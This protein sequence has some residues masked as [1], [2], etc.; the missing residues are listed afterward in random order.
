MTGPHAL[1]FLCRDRHRPRGAARTRRARRETSRTTGTANSVVLARTALGSIR[2][3]AMSGHARRPGRAAAP[4][5]TRYVI[6]RRYPSSRTCG[7]AD[8]ICARLLAGHP[9]IVAVPGLRYPARPGRGSPRRSARRH[10][11]AVSAGGAEVRRS[12]SC[13]CGRLDQEPAAPGGLHSSCSGIGELVTLPGAQ[14]WEPIGT[15]L[16]DAARD[17]PDRPSVKGEVRH[18]RPMNT[19]FAQFSF[20]TR[21]SFSAPEVLLRSQLVTIRMRSGRTGIP[22]GELAEGKRATWCGRSDMNQQ[23]PDGGGGVRPPRRRGRIRATCSPASGYR[24]W[25]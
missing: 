14:S 13:R 20:G 4:T 22:D 8:G 17:C 12:G 25:P 2:V 7:S 5:S 9:A 1:A 23:N 3:G 15:G 24:R 6:A 21:S 10:G 11:R 18:P 16:A 19:I